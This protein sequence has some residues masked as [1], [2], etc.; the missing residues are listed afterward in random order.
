MFFLISYKIRVPVLNKKQMVFLNRDKVVVVVEALFMNIDAG[1]D[2]TMITG[3]P[4]Q[5]SCYSVI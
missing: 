1:R 4:S 3:L 2:A 5:D